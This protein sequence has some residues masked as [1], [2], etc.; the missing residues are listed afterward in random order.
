[1]NNDL[2]SREALK[3]FVNYEMN[4]DR[5]YETEERRDSCYAFRDELFKHIDN[6]PTVNTNDIQYAYDQG[7]KSGYEL[8]KEE[9]PHGEWIHKHLWDNTHIWVCSE[10]GNQNT[11]GITVE[12][13][14]WKCGADM[15]KEADNEI[16]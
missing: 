10:C 6:A 11:H 13:A 14:C 8:G 15:R 1:M 2:I 7:F 9:R 12:K 3:H 5:M 4:T 16:D